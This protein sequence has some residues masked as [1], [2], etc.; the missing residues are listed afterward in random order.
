MRLARGCAAGHPVHLRAAPVKTYGSI[1]MDRLSRRRVIKLLAATGAAAALSRLPGRAVFGASARGGTGTRIP[2]PSPL[3]LDPPAGF[4][5]AQGP[6][7]PTMDS[8]SKYEIPDWYRDAKFG[9][10]AHWGPQCQAEQGDE[11]GQRLYQYS[12]DKNSA[13]QYHLA[14]YGHPSKFGFKD[15]CDLWKA[16]KWNAAALIA[17]YKKAG[18]KYFVQMANDPSNFDMWDSTYQRWNSVK[19][20]PQKDIVGGFAKAAREAG[21]RFAVSSQAGRAWGWYEASQGSDPS[22]SLAGVPYDGWA[23]KADGKGLW[24]EGLDPQD[25]YAQNHARRVR[26]SKDFCEKYFNRIIDL[27]DKHDPDLLYFDDAVFPLNN[28]SDAGKRIAAYLYNRSIQRHGKLEAVMTGKNLNADQRKALL[29]AIDSGGYS[30][31]RIPWQTV[32]SIGDWNYRRSLLDTHGYKNPEQIINLLID[33]VSKNGNLLL[34]IPLPGHGAP[35]DDARKIL[36]ILAAWIAPNGEG[37]FGTRPWVTYGEGP[38]IRR[39]IRNDNR[40]YSPNDY[41]FTRK[42]EIV[43]AFMMGWPA[44]G[45]TT[46]TSLAEGA[47]VQPGSPANFPKKIATVEL[48]GAGEMKFTRDGSGL[49][50]NLPAQKPCDYAS[51]FKITPA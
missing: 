2:P 7:E 33:V 22:G 12:T 9:I 27:I 51:C 48:L 18:A 1:S 40:N 42:G 45:K 15:L 47:N 50:I 39:T 21:L 38:S 36:D 41:R 26:E 23:A 32:F 5:V 16:E 44:D 34:D 11:Y 43:Y 20:G 14:S 17:L 37:L 29:L 46:I 24:W 4:G 10:W 35:D 6:F 13:Y 3:H 30:S 49:I 25:L 28:I 31:D 19:V 8:L